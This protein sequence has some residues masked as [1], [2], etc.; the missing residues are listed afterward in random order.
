ME[1][2]ALAHRIKKTVSL[3]RLPLCG[4]TAQFSAAYYWSL[5]YLVY[6]L[7]CCAKYSKDC[8]LFFIC[9][10]FA[11]DE[12]AVDWL[13]THANNNNNNFSSCDIDFIC[14]TFSFSL[15]RV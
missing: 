10:N 8:T 5:V 4:L 14:A 12:V 13:T 15:L 7:H 6:A 1:L 9:Y 11:A 3:K 2:T